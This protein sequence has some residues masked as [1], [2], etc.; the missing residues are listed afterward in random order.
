M[1][2]M[3]ITAVI[4]T[5]GCPSNRPTNSVKALE[6]NQY[7]SAEQRKLDGNQLLSALRLSS[8]FPLKCATIVMQC[9]YPQGYC[10]T[11]T[12]IFFPDSTFN[13]CI[14]ACFT[15]LSSFIL[16]GGKFSSHELL[17]LIQELALVPLM[18]RSRGVIW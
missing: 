18:L 16:I 8:N 12:D 6:G 13:S 17:T 1:L 2:M 4:P 7:V 3:E 10:F 9:L 15:V 5:L 11:S 14:R